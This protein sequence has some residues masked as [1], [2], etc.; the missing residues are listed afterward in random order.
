MDRELA[1]EL[2]IAPLANLNGKAQSPEALAL[3]RSLAERYPRLPSN[4]ATSSKPYRQKKT[5]EDHEAAVA[6]FLADLLSVCGSKRDTDWA[7]VSLNKDD[8]TGRSVTFRQFNS[9]RKAWTDAGL[10][11]TKPGYPAALAFGNPGPNQGMMTRFRATEALLG[12]KQKL[13]PLGC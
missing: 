3:V 13:G 2:R 11:E 1:G 4:T 8:F 6:A 10:I 9:V 12:A 7:R 5:K